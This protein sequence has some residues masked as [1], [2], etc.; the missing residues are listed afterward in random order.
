M[1]SDAADRSCSNCGATDQK[2]IECFQSFAD[3]QL[4]LTEINV[5][6]ECVVG[7]EVP[8]F[9]PSL[10]DWN[11]GQVKSYDDQ[12]GR[13][14]LEFVD[15][16]TE[17]TMIEEQ[18]TRMYL[19]YFKKNSVGA[20]ETE[21]PVDL[22][23][24]P[25]GAASRHPLNH[26]PISPMKP[27][28]ENKKHGNE[29]CSEDEKTKNQQVLKGVLHRLY[30]HDEGAVDKHKHTKVTSIFDSQ[31][32]SFAQPVADDGTPTSSPT[33]RKLAYPHWDSV[34]AHRENDDDHETVVTNT[35]TPE[36]AR[37]PGIGCFSSDTMSPGTPAARYSSPTRAMVGTIS[38]GPLLMSP[39]IQ[40]SSGDCDPKAT[41]PRMWTLEEDQVLLSAVRSARHPMK[42]PAV[43]Q[44]IPE[45]TGKQCR[46]RYLNH[47]KPK[48]KVESW[49]PAEDALVFH[50]YNSTGSRWA[51]M[52]KLLPGRTD[53]G[54]KNRFH[55]LRR[56]LE[57]DVSR[58]VQHSSTKDAFRAIRQE[59]LRQFPA[60][61]E[62]EG[63]EILPKV[64]GILGYLAA[65]AAKG[66]SPPNHQ[67]SFG[68]FRYAYKEGEQCNRCH[69]FLPSL[70]SGTKLCT[71]TGWC[72]T[73]TRIPAYVSGDML[74]E[75]LNLIQCHDPCRSVIIES[76]GG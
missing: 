26:L 9:R 33:R 59:R 71:Q 4:D 28:G 6:E 11:I 43:A 70:Q 67:Y 37:G 68:P 23:V 21:F 76:W 17:W 30:D 10:H 25:G 47:L 73:C 63:N 22:L 58:G 48:L 61:K 50:L 5:C 46:E 55:H 39:V 62:S 42:W 75:C 53:N 45:R 36:R 29:V 18:P 38:G 1:R 49:S 66:S 20:R 12:T 14:L 2:G 7:R 72:V 56:R 65:T 32:V 64:H 13:H 15:G 54:I 60:G 74:R 8:V 57:K 19:E 16:D 41:K 27:I 69:L 3:E 52:T 35:T 51:R 34:G 31:R 44:A 40:K 24:S